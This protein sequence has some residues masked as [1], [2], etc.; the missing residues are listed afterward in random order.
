[1]RSMVSCSHCHEMNVMGQKVCGS[2]GHDALVSRGECTCFRCR[3]ILHPLKLGALQTVSAPRTVTHTGGVGAGLW[4]SLEEHERRVK[5]MKEVLDA[6]YN[7]AYSFL[8]DNIVDFD[9]DDAEE[10]ITNIRD[11]IETL[12]EEDMEGQPDA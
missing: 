7:E 4:I 10:T 1:M 9:V 8:A 6:C 3:P 2:C 11:Q 12:T 5:K